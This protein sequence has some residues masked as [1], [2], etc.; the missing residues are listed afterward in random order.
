VTK[1]FP[2]LQFGF[3]EGGVA[4]ACEL[5]GGLVGH[6][7]KRN[8]G[9]I[10]NYNPNNID[11]KQL[12]GL[13]AEYG[14]GIPMTGEA[15]AADLARSPNAWNWAND[16][17]IVA[18][19]DRAGI[20]SAEDLRAPFE[21]SF[22][23]GCEADDPYVSVAFDQRLNPFGAKL[24]ALFSSDIGH[25][26]VPDMNEVLAEAYEL[27][28]HELLDLEQFKAFVFEN[29]ATLH[30]RMNPDFFKGTVVEDAAGKLLA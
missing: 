26:D 2:K 14:S 27:V 29:P 11:T 5:Y 17:A 1:R 16:D 15:S 13:F 4:W 28:E 22:Y 25:W 10:D 24:K 6:C 21:Q 20:R 3:L 8:R 19:L 7:G 30:A 23:F 12:A 18:E 9:A